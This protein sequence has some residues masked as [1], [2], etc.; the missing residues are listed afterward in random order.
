MSFLP[1]VK[2]SAVL[3]DYPLL[4]NVG[5]NSL[6][7]RSGFIKP[8]SPVLYHP[9]GNGVSMPNSNVSASTRD[10]LTGYFYS[11]AT[12]TANRNLTLPAAVDIVA[13]LVNKLRNSSS[14]IAGSWFVFAVDNTQ[15]G[16]FTRTL[17]AGAGDTLQ[18]TGFDVSQNEVAFF[19]V[20]VES[21]TAVVVSRYNLG[22]STVATLAETLAAGDTSGDSNIV[23]STA[24]RGIVSGPT[25]GTVVANAVTVNG[26]AGTITDSGTVASGSRTAIVVTNG[27]VAA[28]SQVFIQVG[29]GTTVNQSA[30]LLADAF[31]AGAGSF[32]LNVFNSDGAAATTATPVYYYWIVNPVL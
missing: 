26:T 17:V 4:H 21:A 13:Y 5:M 14:S 25:S 30:A 11:G 20:F 32:T 9:D 1:E 16:A 18:G 7:L 29:Q 24:T 6:N 8:T 3:Q 2:N 23:F 19:Q 22:P 15:A 31:V 10:M 28:N 12:L 27:A